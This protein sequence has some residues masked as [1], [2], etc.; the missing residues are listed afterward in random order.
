M[1]VAVYSAQALVQTLIRLGDL[2][3]ARDSAA[4]SALDQHLG[5]QGV[6]L[7]QCR[8]DRTHWSSGERDV[9]VSPSSRSFA[10]LWA[11]S[12]R[13]PTPA[14]TADAT[15][16]PL[17]IFVVIERSP[18]QRGAGSDRGSGGL[19]RGG[20]GDLQRGR[21]SLGRGSS[22]RG[23]PVHSAGRTRCDACK[24]RGRRR[25]A[26]RNWYGVSRNVPEIHRTACLRPCHLSTFPRRRMRPEWR[27]PVA[28]EI[29]RH[30]RRGAGLAGT[31]P[32]QGPAVSVRTVAGAA[33][34]NGPVAGTRR[35]RANGGGPDWLERP[36][37][38]SRS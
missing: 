11:A 38:G 25:F 20:H 6:R 29:G 34:W 9:G 15:T 26:R 37:A 4:S 36:P 35:E 16:T 2:L 27:T 32:S 31:A 7:L 3:G 23:G 22:R 12:P 30:R 18:H 1:S 28:T 21:R 10:S 13:T 17:R 5:Q 14:A 33:G 8:V 24:S 19:A